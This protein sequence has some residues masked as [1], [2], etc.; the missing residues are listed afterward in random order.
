MRR[1]CGGMSNCK[2]FGLLFLLLSILPA[3]A[4][5]PAPRLEELQVLTQKT[6]YEY[7]A[8]RIAAAQAISKKVALGTRSRFGSEHLKYAQALNNW[9]LFQGLNNELS[10]AEKNF[11]TAIR[12]VEK[13]DGDHSGQLAELKNNLA[14]ISL[15]NCKIGEAQALYSDALRLYLASHGS[16]HAETRM[17]QTNLDGLN[18][19]LGNPGRNGPDNSSS[20]RAAREIGDLLRQCVS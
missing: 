18:Q 3:N 17:A 6:I 14:R 5:K 8:G 16:D 12:I 15:Q 9:A 2:W 1:V 20:T 7:Q 10:E 4:D 19:Y 13:L 11:H